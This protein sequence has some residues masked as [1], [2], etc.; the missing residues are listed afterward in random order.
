M[1]EAEFQ[2]ALDR[3][4]DDIAHWPLEHRQSALALVQSS[5]AHRALW[6]QAKALRAALSAPRTIKAPEGLV[7]RIV[8]AAQGRPKSPDAS[9]RQA[10]SAL[11][12]AQ[13][14]VIPSNLQATRML[15]ANAVSAERQA[16]TSAYLL[17]LALLSG[18]AM[19][20][21]HF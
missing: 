3:W 9:E 16:F 14:G 17:A 7:D 21:V 8:K 6:E 2:D 5:P 10:D 13:F 1:T 11:W 15:V 20:Q 4:G 19:H 12:P 18:L